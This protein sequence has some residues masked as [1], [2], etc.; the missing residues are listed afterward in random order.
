MDKARQLFGLEFDCTHRPYILDPSLTMETQDKVTYLVGRLGGNPAS[1]DGMIAVCQQMFVKAGLPT[2]KRDG[3]T[4]STF[5][6]HRLLLYALTLPGAEETQHK[7][8]HALFT[9][10]FHHGRSMSERD[11]LMAAAADVGIDTEQAG[12]ILNSDAFRSEVR[13]AI[14][15]A[16]ADGVRS[17]PYFRI[18]NQKG[19]SG[20]DSDFL[21]IFKKIAAAPIC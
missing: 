13:T 1:L 12:A 5:D 9:Q 3:L 17:V 20:G 16:A 10:Y 11:A 7:L 8:L 15:E 4:G 18:G 2:L 14:A 21:A 19:F 6:S